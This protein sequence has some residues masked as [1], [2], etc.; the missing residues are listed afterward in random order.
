ML[1]DSAFKGP[2][3]QIGGK[4]LS[5]NTEKNYIYLIKILETAADGRFWSTHTLAPFL[6]YETVLSQ[7]IHVSEKV[8]IVHV[9]RYI[10]LSF[11]Y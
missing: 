4:E 1:R 9:S 2:E 5:T 3:I 11:S 6:A 8:H 7:I 10:L